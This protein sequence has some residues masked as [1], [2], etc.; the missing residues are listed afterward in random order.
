MPAF[1]IGD[2]QLKTE[3]EKYEY[4]L[5]KSFPIVEDNIFQ[6]KSD[7]DIDL[8]LDD[9]LIDEIIRT[10]KNKKANGVDQISNSMIKIIYNHNKN[11]LKTVF[12][13]CLQLVYYS[14]VWKRGKIKIINKKKTKSAKDFRPISLL[15]V[16]GKI[17]E[18]IIEH[19][20]EIYMEGNFVRNDNQYADRKSTG[21]ERAVLKL[22]N[23]C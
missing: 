8:K 3:S 15:P 5:N 11:W 1:E 22:A 17:L 16:L 13:K 21:T 9:D 20:L 10:L 19:H 14:T 6:D 18:K 2:K 12:S 4:L 23:I 7:H